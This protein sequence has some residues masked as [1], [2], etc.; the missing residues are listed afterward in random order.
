MKT[1]VEFSVLLLSAI[2]IISGYAYFSPR[3]IP[4]DMADQHI[5]IARAGEWITHPDGSR[6]CRLTRDLY[7]RQVLQ[8]SDC[9]DW[10]MPVPFT[11]QQVDFLAWSAARGGEI[12]I[13]GK[14]RP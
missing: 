7:Y 13:E 6:A 2:V 11:G 4:V 8:V 3:P 9:T 14:W 1:P 10:T 12:N 5:P